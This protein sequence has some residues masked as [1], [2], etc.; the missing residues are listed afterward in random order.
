MLP[1]LACI[2]CT[3]ARPKL[4]THALQ[5]YLM[6]DYP[7]DRCELIILDDAGQYRNQSHT[8]PK[9]WHL[10]STKRRFRTLGEKRNASAALVSPD[11]DA[12]VVWDD[13]DIYLPWTLKA[14]AAALRKAPWSVPSV[15]LWEEARRKKLVAH[16]TNGLFHAAWA[17]TRE[18]FSR[19]CGYPFMQSGQDQGLAKRFKQAG[20]A[21]TDPITLGFDAYFVQ[22]WGSTRSW[23]LSV[24]DV[25]RGYDGLAQHT[26]QGPP[27][28]ELKP[29]WPL[30]YGK[31]KAGQLTP[32]WSRENAP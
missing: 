30:D 17:F 31:A 9:T 16:A 22:R 13:D 14:H 6:Q 1:K 23:H 3:F 18:A 15:I 11:T 25:R 26:H 10:I 32:R 28:S 8:E 2:C 12:L 7:A 4:L 20:V 5:S 24:M 19:V 21:R 27:I 29:C